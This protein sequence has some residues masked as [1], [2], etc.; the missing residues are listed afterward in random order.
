MNIARYAALAGNVA[1]ILWIVWNGIDDG[2]KDIQSVQAASLLG[3][4]C[5]LALNF[6]L[7][8]SKEIKQRKL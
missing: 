4:L 8:Y 7:L 2:F 1:Y 3:L 5:L 6:F